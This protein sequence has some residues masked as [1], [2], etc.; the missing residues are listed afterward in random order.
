MF[1]TTPK[2][3]PN[4]FLWGASTSA[5]QVEGASE[6]HGKGPSIQ[7]LHHPADLSDFSVASD[8]YHHVEEDVA[9][10]KELGLK[11]YRF[12]ISWSRIFP[13]G[14][15]EINPE[16]VAF[17][18]TLIDRL[19]ASGI[20]PVV[21]LYHFDLPLAL[22]ENGGWSNRETID[23]FAQYAKT[24]FQEYGDKVKYWLTINEQNVMINH[25][26]AMN[27]GKTPTNKELYQ[28]NHHMLLAGAI[29]TNLCH[30][31][32]PE[33]KIGP[34]PNIIAV[35]PKTCKPEDVVAADNWEAIRNW[36]YLDVAVKGVYN[37]IAWAYMEEKGL[38]PYM[39]AGDMDLLASA[40]PDFLGVNYY[41]TATVSAAKNDGHDRA[42]RNGDQQTMVGE[43]GVYRAETNDLLETTEFGWQIDSVGLRTTL[44]RVYDRYHLPI[45]ITENGIGARD[46]LEDDG[47]V[48]DAYRVDYLRRHFEQ[49]RLAFSDGVDLIGYCPW[50]FMDLVS[51]HQGYQKRY[52]FVYIDRQEKDLK[53]LQ[54]VKKDSFAWYQN[55]IATN[56]SR[57]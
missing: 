52:G 16:G 29:A 55:V 57:M 31:L 19:V 42:P 38:V 26:A 2:P 23:A 54:R 40:K 51:T 53:T 48:H 43:E 12:S 17:Y 10:M 30:E 33:G 18:H 21:T 28:Q 25:P 45:L 24:L 49:A 35:Y 56:G 6:S 32:V 11:A 7:D 1:H 27:P 41:A 46:A 9:L 14:K 37:P 47:T 8:H 4:D 39:E 20:E 3:F 22:Y 34:A 36:L 44:R 5:Y 15:G 13:K 50:A